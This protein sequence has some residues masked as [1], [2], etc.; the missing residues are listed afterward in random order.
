MRTLYRRYCR[1]ATAVPC[2]PLPVVAG[3]LLLAA[4]Y[5]TI[6]AV[7]SHRAQILAVLRDVAA[8]A[9]VLAA[10]GL[11][12]VMTR[13]IAAC[14]GQHTDVLPGDEPE[15]V[16]E[17]VQRWLSDDEKAGLVHRGRNGSWKAGARPGDYTW[18]VRPADA[19]AM[20]ADADAF[21]DRETGV[22]V[23]EDGDIYELAGPP[24]EDD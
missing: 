5:I 18:R 8:V 2:S 22:V 15:T 10:A 13:R 9:L 14:E 6:P 17:S 20:T 7:L 24:G 11:L 12:T 3:V 4:A 21:A 19:A 23:S 1:S 16:T